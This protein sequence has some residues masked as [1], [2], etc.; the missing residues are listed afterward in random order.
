[1]PPT[2]KGRGCVTDSGEKVL[3]ETERKEE[4]KKVPGMIETQKAGARGGGNLQ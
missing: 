3:G 2:D 1:M 4:R